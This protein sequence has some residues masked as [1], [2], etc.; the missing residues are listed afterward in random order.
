MDLDKAV[1]EIFTLLNR[2]RSDPRNAAQQ[3]LSL[4]ERYSDKM[5]NQ[6]IKTREGVAAL[7]DLLTDLKS[8]PKNNNNL[9][10][11]FALHMVADEQAKLLGENGLLTTEGS[12]MHKSLPLRCEPYAVIDGRLSE[13]YEFGG[14]SGQ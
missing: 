11:S 10:W 7:Y 2:V 3:M 4:K 13:V 5:Y 8:R 9:K 12:N 1:D 6:N 14:E